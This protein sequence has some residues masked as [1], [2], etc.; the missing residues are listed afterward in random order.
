MAEQPEVDIRFYLNE[1]ETATADD[2][3]REVLL[4]LDYV[5]A[6]VP[7]ENDGFGRL[8]PNNGRRKDAE[9]VT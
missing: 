9:T 6:G 5:Q 1:G 7:L 4:N 2:L 8:M 3:I